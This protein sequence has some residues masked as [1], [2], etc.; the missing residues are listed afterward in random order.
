MDQT[1]KTAAEVFEESLFGV[2]TTLFR[3]RGPRRKFWSWFELATDFVQLLGSVASP[4]FTW[5]EYTRAFV[6]KYLVNLMLFN[7]ITAAGYDLY[8]YVWYLVVSSLFGS[9]LV[10][11]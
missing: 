8:R 7:P 2:M 1:Q 9:C 3:D 11:V 10:V 6:R 4:S 5:G